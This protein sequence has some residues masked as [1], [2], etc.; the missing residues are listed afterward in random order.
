MAAADRQQAQPADKEAVALEAT[1]A[2]DWVRGVM[3]TPPEEFW[4]LSG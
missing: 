2:A 1:V 4:N 3:E